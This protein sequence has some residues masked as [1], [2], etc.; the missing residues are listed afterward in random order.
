M[1]SFAKI[2]IASY[3]FP[4]LSALSFAMYE[5]LIGLDEGAS[6]ESQLSFNALIN[7]YE[8]GVSPR[9]KL[10]MRGCR[11]YK[12]DN[13][14]SEKM[15]TFNIWFEAYKMPGSYEAY[16]ESRNK[17]VKELLWKKKLLVQAH[18]K[19]LKG[20]RNNISYSIKKERSGDRLII[21]FD[22]GSA[23]QIFAICSDNI[24]FYLP[25]ILY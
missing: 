23:R 16:V 17:L 4:A 19:E 24:K 8:N 21:K 1:L 5:P 22:D 11:L 20:E 25:N 18:D 3:I 2:F 9:R 14:S 12:G 6:H 13:H 10:Y 15:G 7:E